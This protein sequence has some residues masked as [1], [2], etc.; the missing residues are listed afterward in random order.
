MVSL[1]E[2]RCTFTNIRRNRSIEHQLYEKW[3]E[4]VRR[5]PVRRYQE[6]EQ[7]VHLKL[8]RQGEAAGNRCLIGELALSNV[9]SREQL[10][11]TSRSDTGQSC[12]TAKSSGRR[13]HTRFSRI[14]TAASRI[15]ILVP[16]ELCYFLR[17]IQRQWQI[18]R[19][20]KLPAL[21]VP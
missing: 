11:L 8:C 17:H 19:T 16:D 12:W 18:T 10:I 15:R 13:P 4:D 9:S 2:R 1:A 14:S 5:C 3:E 6:R 20:G 21:A 7:D